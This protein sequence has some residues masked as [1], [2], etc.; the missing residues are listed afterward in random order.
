MFNFQSLDK[1]NTPQNKFDSMSTG[2]TFS[3]NC[4]STNQLSGFVPNRLLFKNPPSLILWVGIPRE[5]GWG[6]AQW[7][8]G[9]RRQPEKEARLAY[10][11]ILG[12]GVEQET[13][14][15]LGLSQ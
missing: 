1:L 15:P 10:R 9:Q 8:E 7:A 2:M 3:R 12:L 4:A 5:R 14:F 6:A 13:A 11:V